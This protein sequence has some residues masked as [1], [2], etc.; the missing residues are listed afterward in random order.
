MNLRKFAQGQTCTARIPGVCNQNPETTV[1]A[2]CNLFGLGGMSWKA[3]DLC[4]C[5]DC[6]DAL[7]RRTSPESCFTEVQRHELWLGAVL[8]TLER[9]QEKFVILHEDDCF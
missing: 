4:A 3:P 5:S 1:L 2:H 8:R 6:H 9:V 7:D